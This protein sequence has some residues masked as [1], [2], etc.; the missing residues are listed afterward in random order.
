MD[1]NTAVQIFSFAM[2]TKMAKSR[3]KGRL[4]WQTCSVDELKRMMIDHIDK[5]DMVDVANFA[6]MI[7]HNK[8]H[9]GI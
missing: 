3:D 7:W 8:R 1:D 6:M 2:E 4:G 5:G 9:A